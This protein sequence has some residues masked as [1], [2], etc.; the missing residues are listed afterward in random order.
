MHPWFRHLDGI[1]A[2]LVRI[3]PVIL[4]AAVN[5]YVHTPQRIHDTDESVEVSAHVVIDRDT[6]VIEQRLLDQARSPTRVAVELPI[7]V[8]EID[9]THPE[10]GD[11][12]VEVARNG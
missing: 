11:V 2:V 7:H 12:Q 6:Q 8:G 10:T 5:W 3:G 4:Q 9:A 1:F